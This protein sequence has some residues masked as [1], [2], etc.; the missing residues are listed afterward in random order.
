T[1][2]T[3][4]PGRG[5]SSTANTIIES[6]TG[7]LRMTSSSLR[8]KQEVEDWEP[9]PEDVLKLQPRSW[10]EKPGLRPDMPD[11]QD[12]NRYVG[13]IA[14]EVAEAGLEELVVFEEDEDGNYGPDNLNYDRIPAAHQV[15]LRDHEARILEL[16]GE[17]RDLRSR[18]AAI[19]E[20]LTGDNH[21]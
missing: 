1:I 4:K 10:K 5:T 15:V 11:Y 18:L 7:I 21:V 9:S 13:F 19:E 16:E 8:Y 12:P 6:G 2:A 20:R 3:M 14:E 17:N